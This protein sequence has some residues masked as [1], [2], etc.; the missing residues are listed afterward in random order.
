MPWPK[1]RPL[2]AETR[3]KLST[4]R[5]G[6]KLSLTHR[7]SISRSLLGKIRTE[8]SRV[9]IS[10]GAKKRDP[11]TRSKPPSHLGVKRSRGTLERMR[12]S[13]LAYLS[14]PEN[15]AKLCAVAKSN[16]AKYPRNI[17]KAVLASRGARYTRPE[18]LFDALTPDYVEYTGDKRFWLVF[19]DGRHKNPDFVVR[20]FSTT[21]TVVEIF[22]SYWHSKDEEVSL[23]GQYAEIGVRC[24]V[25]WESDVVEATRRLFR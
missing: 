8:E 22:G 4:V 17:I 18:R 24:I 5:R 3:L 11:S 12:K 2:S 14:I 25:I 7:E 23:V 20:P 1:G 21:K 9:R 13:Q 19:K 15:Y 16:H 10:V 6:R